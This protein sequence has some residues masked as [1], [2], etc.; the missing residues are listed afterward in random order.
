[1]SLRK[2]VAVAI[3]AAV[4]AGCGA[5]AAPRGKSQKDTPKQDAA[6]LQVRLGRGYLEQGKFETAHEKLE[7][8]L[9]LDPASIDAHTLMAI[10]YERIDRPKLSEKHYRRAA[11][12]DPEDGGANNNLGAYLC[13]YE[14]Y[15][16]ADAYFIKALDDPFY[17]T[18]QAAWSNAGVCAARSGNAGKAEEYFRRSLEINPKDPAALYELALINFRKNEFLRARGFIQ[19]FESVGQADAEALDLA[20]RIEDELGDAAAAAKY[21]ERLKSEFP[22]RE[23]GPASERSKSP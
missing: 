19:R 16:E 10:L 8:A 13:R 20:A 9:E 2:A 23:P 12:L 14:R 11:E 22:D 6:E 5:S 7:R 15:A 4:V 3:L 18:P 1:M 21:R 17:A